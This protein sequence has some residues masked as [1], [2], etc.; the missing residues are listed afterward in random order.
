MKLTQVRIEGLKCPPKSATFSSL[1][2]NSV[3]SGSGHGERQQD[4][5][6]TIR[7]SRAEAPHPARLMQRRLVGKARDAVRAIM[8]DVAK[9]I[10]PAAERKKAA[11]E[12]RVKA[13]HEALTLSA[14]LSDWQALHLA[15]KR[16][17]YAS[18]AVRAVRNA[19]PDISTSPPPIS[20]GQ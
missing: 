15:S 10:D 8:G 20:T 4:L 14:L 2:M 6:G 11:A 16:P 19:F 9:G 12:A 1:M 3:G 7:L 17:R 18:E 13:A 5:S